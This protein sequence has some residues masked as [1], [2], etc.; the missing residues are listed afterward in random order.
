MKLKLIW[1]PVFGCKKQTNAEE[2]ERKSRISNHLTSNR[3]KKKTV[4][5]VECFQALQTAPRNPTEK[6]TA[7]IELGQFTDS[8]E[9]VSVDLLNA[10]A[11]QRKD[12]QGNETVE[13]MAIHVRNLIVA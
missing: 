3:M 13:C 4:T 7:Q 5:Y 11:V 12:E 8:N 6:V 2:T 9:R 10:I 1:T